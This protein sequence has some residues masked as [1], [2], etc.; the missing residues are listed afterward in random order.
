RCCTQFLPPPLI[1]NLLR[2][3]VIMINTAEDFIALRGS[4]EKAECDG[5]AFEEASINVWN[6]VLDRYP[7]YA[8]CHMNE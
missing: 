2:A 1:L 7:D 8:K 5:A 6:D 3:V 4:E